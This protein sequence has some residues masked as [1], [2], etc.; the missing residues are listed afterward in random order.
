MYNQLNKNFKLALVVI[1][2]QFFFIQNL[3]LYY[4]IWLLLLYFKNFFEN[5]VFKLSLIGHTLISYLYIVYDY[6][7][8]DNIT[9]FW[10]MQQF[11]F[12]LNCNT[13]TLLNLDGNLTQYE[14]KPINSSQSYEC[15]DD[16][17]FGPFS[18][19]IQTS[20]NIEILTIVFA[21][22]Y[23]LSILFFQ[24]QNVQ[25]KF[26][27]YLVFILMSPS[28]IF[29]FT[30]LNP[31]IVILFYFISRL[32]SKNYMK[33]INIFDYLILS[34]FIQ[35]KIFPIA[36]LFGIVTYQILKNKKAFNSII[37]FIV[38]L[39]TLIYYF[40]SLTT[41]T[42]AP[43]E[44]SSLNRT[45]GIYSDFVIL[46][47]FVFLL[48]LYLLIIV[49]FIVFQNKYTFQKN[50]EWFKDRGET[51][52]LIYLPLILLILSFANY[53]YK[54]SFILIYLISSKIFF[55]KKKKILILIYV[56]LT[57]LIYFF[58]FSFQ[59]EPLNI[60]FLILNKL[61]HVYFYSFFVVYYFK[62]FKSSYLEYRLK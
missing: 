57:P 54:F 36:V 41:I 28:L 42:R 14:Y 43:T 46:E 4:F 62:I 18:F 48:F 5:K 44:L 40:F 13:N 10:D 1:S 58:G 45:F 21:G 59:L 60:S 27:L 23:I 35:V 25:T 7:S 52:D 3:F 47:K 39:F 38:N 24:F 9:I 11:L 20:L 56:I 29:M 19:L 6:L 34:F 16:V 51:I 26:Y 2:L 17:G 22:A 32:F 49:L 61:I 8:K 12:L 30:S 33:E 53:G 15:F 37:F 31:D 55:D 50:D